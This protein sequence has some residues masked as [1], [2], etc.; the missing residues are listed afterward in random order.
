MTIQRLIPLGLAALAA[1]TGARRAAESALA[2]ADSAIAALPAEAQNISP[3]QVKTLNEAVKVGRQAIEAG[4]YEAAS[5]SL[6]GLAEQA[7][8]LVDSLPSRRAALTAEMDTLA[9]AMPRNLEGIK[10][11]LDKIARTRRLPAGLD[12]QQLQEA[13]DTHATAGPLWADITQAFASG[14]LAD[15]MD[16]A[17]DLKARVSRVML[18]L[19]MVADERAWSNVTLP[20]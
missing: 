6:Y 1:C 4:D 16:R 18:S 5:T 19:G 15:A 2:A 9:I 20:R 13:K 12:Q 11:E 8:A 3:E 17:H 14:K 7:Q 10:V